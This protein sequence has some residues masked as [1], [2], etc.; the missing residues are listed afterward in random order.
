METFL[1]KLTRG[2]W[3]ILLP[4]YGYLYLRLKLP[5]KVLPSMCQDR[6]RSSVRLQEKI[7]WLFCWHS[8]QCLFLYQNL[9]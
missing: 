4:E 7:A 8:S 6:V 3:P 1:T 9:E 2:F 5:V